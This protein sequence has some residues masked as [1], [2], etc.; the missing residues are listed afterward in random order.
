M[1]ILQSQPSYTIILL[2]IK[3]YRLKFQSSLKLR[4]HQGLVVEGC[5]VNPNW[6]DS[7]RKN[8]LISREG[9]KTGEKPEERLISTPLE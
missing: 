9:E 2:F 3:R 6:S 7:Y 1:K 8:E 5:L 4:A